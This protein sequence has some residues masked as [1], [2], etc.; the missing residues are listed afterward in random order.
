MG[1]YKVQAYPE[2]E[3]DWKGQVPKCSLPRKALKSKR[4]RAPMFLRDLS[5]VVSP[6]SA[7]YTRT[8]LHPYFP[9][10]KNR[11]TSLVLMAR[12]GCTPSHEWPFVI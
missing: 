3:G 12:L 7:R 10:A 6:H 5:Q 11:E 1:A 4:F 9:V 2:S 8:F